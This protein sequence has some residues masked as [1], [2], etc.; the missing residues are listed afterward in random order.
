MAVHG[1]APSRIA[2]ATYSVV[3]LPSIH[4]AKITWRKSQARKN[5]VHGLMSQFATSV[6]TSPF[7]CRRTP[8]TLLQSLW[9]HI[10]Q[11]ITQLRTESTR[12]NCTTFLVSH[13][14]ASA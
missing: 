2:P 8:R 3:R 13:T 14:P 12:F 11:I 5:I 4:G 9:L 6:T 10:G 1:A 7:G